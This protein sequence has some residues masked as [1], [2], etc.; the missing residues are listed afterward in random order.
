M[1]PWLKHF[2]VI[3][4]RAAFLLLRFQKCLPW[5]RL[6]K[7]KGS[8]DRNYCSRKPWLQECDNRLKQQWGRDGWNQN[9]KVRIRTN[10]SKVDFL[11]KFTQ[12]KSATPT[13]T[14]PWYSYLSY[15]YQGKQ[16]CPIV[17]TPVRAYPGLNF[18]PGFFFFLSKALSPDNFLY[19]F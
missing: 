4:C 9:A 7:G 16:L 8:Y 1:S 14:A 3:I 13:C 6:W 18:N 12:G 10:V 15:F 5:K 17:R 2:S 19:S 11:H